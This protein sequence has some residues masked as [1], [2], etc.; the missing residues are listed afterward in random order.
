MMNTITYFE[1]QASDPERLISFYEDVFGWEFVRE[2]TLPIVYYRIQNAGIYGGMMRR[3]GKTPPTKYGTNAF[4]CSVQVD[5][6]DVMA[7]TILGV[8][9]EIEMT[10]FAVP[11]RCWQGYFRDPDNNIFGIFEVDLNAK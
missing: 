8:G 7:K 3:P 10:K 4:M 11:G 1:I 2:E 5:D 6:F 9:G